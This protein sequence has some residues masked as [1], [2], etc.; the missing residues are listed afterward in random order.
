[1]AG[2]KS[3]VSNRSIPEITNAGTT[4]GNG[5]ESDQ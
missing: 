2:G 4:G 3:N 1:L 5:V